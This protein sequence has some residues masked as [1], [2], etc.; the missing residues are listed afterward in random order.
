MGAD[1][2]AVRSTAPGLE[3]SSVIRAIRAC[4]VHSLAG[5]RRGPRHFVS[6]APSK[7]YGLH[8]RHGVLTEGY[9][10][11]SQQGCRGALSQALLSGLAPVTG[12]SAAANK[13]IHHDGQE[14]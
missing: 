6:R 3:I 11:P 2:S 13:G 9:L 14:P 7:A 10:Q 8:K 1:Q 5:R 4:R 12:S